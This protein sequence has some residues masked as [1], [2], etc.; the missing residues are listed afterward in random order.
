M[1]WDFPPPPFLKHLCK[2]SIGIYAKVVLLFRE[3]KS[4]R[5]KKDKNALK[6][7]WIC[8][9]ACLYLHTQEQGRY[10]KQKGK[11][12]NTLLLS[13]NQTGHKNRASIRQFALSLKSPEE[14]Y[15]WGAVTS[16]G[17]QGESRVSICGCRRKGKG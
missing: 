3:C 1:C 13:A 7:H 5:Q 10:N 6:F 8:P 11:T 4:K 2:Y 9:G 14:T 17:E 16:P 15:F 12:N